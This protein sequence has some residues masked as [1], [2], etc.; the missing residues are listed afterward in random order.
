MRSDGSHRRRL[1][2]DPARDMEPAFSPN[3]RWIVF[4][5]LRAGDPELYAIHPDGSGE[6]RITHDRAIEESPDWAP[7]L[8]TRARKP[9][10][11]RETRVGRLLLEAGGENAVSRRLPWVR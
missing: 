1:T 3:G 6:R 8:R 2:T 4:H 7:R 10:E 9:A 5:S 11:L